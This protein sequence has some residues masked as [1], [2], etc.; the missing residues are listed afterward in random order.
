M[1]NKEQYEKIAED[2]LGNSSSLKETLA[3]HE[4]TFTEAD[5]EAFR[6]FAIDCEICGV[7]CDPSTICQSENGEEI[8]EDCKD[9]E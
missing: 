3:Y 8:C 1:S 9:K 4:V 6:A 5:R 7:W 2:L